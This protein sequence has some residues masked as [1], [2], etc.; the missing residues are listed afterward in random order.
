MILPHLVI[1][2]SVKGGDGGLGVFTTSFFEVDTTIEISPVLLF[3]KEERLHLE[4]TKLYHYIFEWGENKESAVIGLGFVSMYNHSYHSNCE[5][6]MDYEAMT[7]TI[8][9]VKEIQAGEE[10]F[11][12]YNGDFD[13]ATPLWFDAH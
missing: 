4:K 2:P 13:D 10:L 1:A 7:M 8:K 6:E 3:T 12:N 9:T 11:I 5:Y